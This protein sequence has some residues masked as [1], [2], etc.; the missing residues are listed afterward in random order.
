MSEGERRLMGRALRVTPGDAVYHEE[1][2]GRGN[3][4]GV[5]C[6]RDVVWEWKY[7]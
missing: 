5:V 3:D 2:K 6:G 1:K 4:S 7:E